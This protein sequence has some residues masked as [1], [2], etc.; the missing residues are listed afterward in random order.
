MANPVQF[1]GDAPDI[2][3]LKIN[4]FYIGTETPLPYG[5][6]SVTGYFAGLTPP[7]T[8]YVAYTNKAS[9]GPSIRVLDSTEIIPYLK[10]FGFVTGE[11][12]QLGR[13]LSSA[14]QQDN[15]CITNKDLELINLGATKTSLPF[16]LDGGFTPCFADESDTVVAQGQTSFIGTLTGTSSP[17][18]TTQRYKAS[19]GGSI[20][21]DAAN[22]D[23]ITTNLLNNSLFQDTFTMQFW[24]YVDGA[25]TNGTL[26]Y[27]APSNGLDNSLEIKIVGSGRIEITVANDTRTTSTA[28]LTQDAWNLL[29]IQLTSNTNAVRINNGTVDAATRTAIGSALT[30]ITST[31]AVLMGS[32]G[33]TNNFNG[34]IAVFAF[35]TESLGQ[36]AQLQNWNALKAR[37]GLT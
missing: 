9:G 20:Q 10:S 37:F 34:N 1:K 17:A 27:K 26:F 23:I 14:S 16:Y 29:S 36:A 12:N 25:Q 7:S 24:V 3:A 30:N 6:T 32:E 5:P 31:A 22:R 33:T 13:C 4:N 11:D 15:L 35:Y 2:A 19:N 21:F 18:G 28:A 8:E